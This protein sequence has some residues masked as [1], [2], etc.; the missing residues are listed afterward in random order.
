MHIVAHNKRRLLDTKEEGRKMRLKMKLKGTESC[1]A[2]ERQA[3]SKYYFNITFV[4]MVSCTKAAERMILKICVVQRTQWEISP[5]SSIS[6]FYAGCTPNIQEFFT[7]IL[8]KRAVFLCIV[9]VNFS[10]LK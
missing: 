1:F 10:Q 6:L 9:R 5:L 2:Y 4:T 8:W 7:Y 3:N